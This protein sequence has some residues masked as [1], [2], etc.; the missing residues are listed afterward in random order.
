MRATFTRRTFMAAVVAGGA[1]AAAGCGSPQRNDAGG[2]EEANTTARA[3]GAPAVAPQLAAM[4]VYRDPSCGC[5]EA[6]AEIARNAGYPVELIDH[7]D[8]PAIKRQYGV[9]D[10]L[11]SCH[12]AIVGGYAIEGHVPMEEVKRLL[13]DK[14]AGVRGIAVAGMPLGSPGMEVPD[15]TKEP[16]RVMAF[17]ANGRTSVFRG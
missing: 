4:T 3:G 8:M 2:T 6:W 7:P 15:G 5:C 11:L 1:L 13:T 12:T 17:D 9:P 14:P 10:E 16:F